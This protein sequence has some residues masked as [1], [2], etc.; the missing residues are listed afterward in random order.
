MAVKRFQARWSMEMA[1]AMA[2][3]FGVQLAHSL[4]FTK[5]ELEVDA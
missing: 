3:K 2:T 4:G 5:V 1:E